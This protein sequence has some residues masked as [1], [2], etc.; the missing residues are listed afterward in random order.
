MYN[1]DFLVAYENRFII[2][3]RGRVVWYC[4]LENDDQQNVIDSTHFNSIEFQN[5][6]VCILNLYFLNFVHCVALLDSTGILWILTINTDDKSA[7]IS[8]MNCPTKV[9]SIFK[10][11][12]LVY[13]I[14]IDG[15]A[16][17]F[18]YY[19]TTNSLQKHEALK[20]CEK[21]IS[22]KQVHFCFISRWKNIAKSL[23]SNS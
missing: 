6:I 10:F 23:L 4:F 17:I 7:N 21:C 18:D 16:W 13:L 9:S 19:N 1:P 20:K 11:K 15:S 5:E 8:E 14:D 22:Q 2:G 3:S 12:H